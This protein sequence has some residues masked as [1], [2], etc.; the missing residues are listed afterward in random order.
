[1]RQFAYLPDFLATCIELSGAKYP[2][3]IPMHEGKSIVNSL[4][5]SDR[6]IHTEPVFWEHEGNA[7]V[8]WGKWKLVR[9][10]QRP[11]ELFDIENDRSEMQNLASKE[12]EKKNELVE[13]WTQWASKNQVAFP[14]RFNM[15]EFLREKKKRE[16]EA[17]KSN[18]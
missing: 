4:R 1:M 9:E 3:N 5:G 2:S 11:W 17:G 18:S 7:A 8:R 16:S 15:Y 10:Y 14:K 6:P 13:M 12:I